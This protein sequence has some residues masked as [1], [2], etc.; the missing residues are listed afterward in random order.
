[1]LG[2]SLLQ[3]SNADEAARY[4]VTVQFNTTVTQDDL[5][6]AG[7][8]LGTYDN[9]LEFLIMEIFPPIGRATLETDTPDFCATVVAELEAKSYVRSV[10]C[11]RAVEA[12][13]SDADSDAPVAA[14]PGG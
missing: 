14:T 10:E 3:G 5:D 11:S 4:E 8:L 12:D 1:M 2:I 7:A 9:D 13:E 6:E